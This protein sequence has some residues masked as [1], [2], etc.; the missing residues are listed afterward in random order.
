MRVPDGML[1]YQL[2][3]RMVKYFV[4]K[5]KREYI[6][7]MLLSSSSKN[8][9]SPSAFQIVED[10]DKRKVTLPDVWVRNVVCLKA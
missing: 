3:P 10:W 6:L 2:L 8:T 9:A 5:L 4:T 7:M 1:C